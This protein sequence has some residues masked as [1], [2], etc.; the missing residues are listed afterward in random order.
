MPSVLAFETSSH[1]GSVCLLHEGRAFR[2]SAREDVKLSAWLLP[3]ISRVLQAAELEKT[4]IDA[5]AFGNGPGSFTGVRTACAT[6]QALAYALHKPL[7]SVDSMQAFAVEAFEALLALDGESIFNRGEHAIEVILDA[8]MNELYRQ[9]LL[10]PT[11]DKLNN[12]DCVSSTTALAPPELVQIEACDAPLGIAVGSGAVLL[13]ARGVQATLGAALV[14]EVTEHSERHWAD[15][16]ANIALSRL[17]KGHPAIMPTDAA[18]N[19]VRNNVAK[20]ELERAQEAQARNV[21]S[22]TPV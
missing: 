15:A 3:A 17:Q 19:Y 5:V 6:A 22:H 8:R 4:Q 13:Q 1:V 10:F 2:E 11:R 14:K 21:A 12:S 20:T 7:F 18:P 9:Q 16:I